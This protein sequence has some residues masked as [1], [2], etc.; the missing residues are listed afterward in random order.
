MD[1]GAQDVYE[2]DGGGDC[3]PSHRDV[4][5]YGGPCVEGNTREGAPGRRKGEGLKRRDALKR[6]FA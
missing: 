3:G 2:H 4:C 1:P 6:Q 5:P